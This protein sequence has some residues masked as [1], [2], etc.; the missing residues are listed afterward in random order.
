MAYAAEISRAQ[1]CCLIFLLDPSR[2][3]HGRFGHGE[4]THSKAQG[5]AD[6]LNRLLINLVLRCA[7]SEGIRDYFYVAVIGY[8]HPVGTLF[9]GALAGND[10]VPVSRLAAHPLRIERRERL[11]EGGERAVVNV[12]L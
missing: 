7:R 5:V 3:M 6:A 1:P 9:G 2:S 4:Y 11:F 10:L 12:P 8:G